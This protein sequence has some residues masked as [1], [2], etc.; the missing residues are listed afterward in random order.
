[1][2]KIPKLIDMIKHDFIT[3]Y[4]INWPTDL[5][6]DNSGKGRWISPFNEYINEW[7]QINYSAALI[8]DKL[9]YE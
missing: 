6:R 8:I 1:M 9:R 4:Q 5:I 3:I 2:K 7:T